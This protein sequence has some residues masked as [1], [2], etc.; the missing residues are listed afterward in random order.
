MLYGRA[1]TA[2]NLISQ[3]PRFAFSRQ[4]AHR[5]IDRTKLVVPARWHGRVL[6]FGGSR[7]DADPMESA[8][9]RCSP[10]DSL[11]GFWLQARWRDLGVVGETTGEEVRSP[12]HEL[13]GAADFLP[14]CGPVSMGGGQRGA[15]SSTG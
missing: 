6:E 2:R 13:R 8:L 1:A 14:R 9:L 10:R 7:R 12:R 15:T 3:A 5:I 11:R 4:E